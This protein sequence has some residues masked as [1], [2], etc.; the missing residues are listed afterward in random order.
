MLWD[1]TIQLG[2][3][4]FN[5]IIA[6]PVPIDLHVLKAVKRSPLGLDLYL[7]LTYRTFTL[8]AP[9]RLSWKQLYRQFGAAPRWHPAGC[10]ERRAS[11]GPGRSTTGGESE[12]FAR[13]VR[14]VTKRHAERIEAGENT[15]TIT[16]AMAMAT[17]LG[18]SLESI[19][20]QDPDE[21]RPLIPSLRRPDVL[22]G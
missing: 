12:N 16:T 15:P 9:L 21:G 11:A 18:V 8:K 5:E 19:H 2:E 1:S 13:C 3:Q 7:W 6:H 20:H 4:Y 10:R 17:V 14:V 22:H